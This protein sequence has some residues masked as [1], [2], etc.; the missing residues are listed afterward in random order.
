MSTRRTAPTA[1]GG[2]PRGP[3]GEALCRRCREPVGRGRKT[4]CGDACVH[5]WKV[6]TN[7]AY[8]SMCVERR[9]H[10]VCAICRV[11]TVELY[12]WRRYCLSMVVS[13]GWPPERRALRVWDVQSEGTFLRRLGTEADITWCVPAPDDATKRDVILWLR[14][15][16]AYMRGREIVP[17]SRLWD[18]DH[19]IPVVEGGGEV[20]LDGLRTLCVPCH[21]HVTRELRARLAEARRGA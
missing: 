4:F 3:D 7:P 9:D 17:R 5:E 11:D 18:M 21:R 8:A 2:P 19:T 10:G 12:R 16:D 15:T 14:I 1:S 20:G 13:Y 6:R